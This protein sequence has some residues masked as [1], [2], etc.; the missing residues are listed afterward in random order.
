MCAA[1]RKLAAKD[2][3]AIIPPP[4]PP[5]PD[6]SDVDSYDLLQAVA[7]T[8]RDLHA[9]LNHELLSAKGNEYTDLSAKMLG[10]SRALPGV[11]KELRSWEE[12]RDLA[13]ENLSVEQR[14]ELFEGF[15]RTMPPER[16]RRMVQRLTAVATRTNGVT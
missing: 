3:D 4:E 13:A 5:A 1:C 7:R 9:R 15:F 6:A 12:R 8:M 16:Q 2:V 11:T 10:L 14:E